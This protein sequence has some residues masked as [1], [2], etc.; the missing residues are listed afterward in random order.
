MLDNLTGYSKDGVG[1]VT[2]HD[3]DYLLTDDYYPLTAIV[4]AFGEGTD[5]K[6][7]NYR[8]AKSVLDAKEYFDDLNIVAQAE[9]AEI[10]DDLGVECERIG[11]LSDS[12]QLNSEYSSKEIIQRTKQYDGERVYIAHPAHIQRVKN[13]GENLGLSGD[14]FTPEKVE[15]P[16]KDQQRWVRSPKKWVAREIWVRIHHKIKGWI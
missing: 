10:L 2:I 3:R 8:L 12:S 16:S 4:L 14:I 5:N 9:V 13:I 1:K 15:W 7:Y 11:S 6:S